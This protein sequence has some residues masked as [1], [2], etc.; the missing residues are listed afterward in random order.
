M[1]IWLRPPSFPLRTGLEING[2]KGQ[3]IVHAWQGSIAQMPVTAPCAG[4][5]PYSLCHFCLP[6]RSFSTHVQSVRRGCHTH[7]LAEKGGRAQEQRLLAVAQ[8]TEREPSIIHRWSSEPVEKH[9]SKRK[10]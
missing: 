2:L 1:G 7:H 8:T 4:G 3:I 9:D 6:H 5:I 10:C